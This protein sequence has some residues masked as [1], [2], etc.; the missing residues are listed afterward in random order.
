MRNLYQCSF[1]IVIIFTSSCQDNVTLEEDVL[2]SSEPDETGNLYVNNRLNES[3]LLYRASTLLREIPPNSG[4]FLVYI[5][6]TQGNTVDLKIWRKNDV[7]DLENPDENVV[8]KRWVVLLS[9]GTEEG[10]RTHWIID[11]S[12]LSF[13]GEINFSYPDIFMNGNTNLY[14]VDVYLNQMT[15]AK[16]VSLSPGV[17]INVGLG[18]NI[19]NLYYFYWFSDEINTEGITPVGWYDGSVQFLLNSGNNSVE[20]IIPTYDNSSIGRRGNII[21]TNNLSEIIRINAN[22]LPISYYMIQDVEANS[23]LDP[24]DSF[25]YSIQVGN[26]TFEARDI[27]NTILLENI[28][29]ID[30]VEE[31]GFSWEVDGV[32]DM[33]DP[34][35]ILMANQTSYRFTLHDY[36]SSSYLGYF[37]EGNTTVSIN[38]NNTQNNIKA[39]DYTNTVGALLYPVNESWEIKSINI[40]PISELVL[41]PKFSFS[42]YEISLCDNTIIDIIDTEPYYPPASV[43]FRDISLSAIGDIEYWEWNINGIESIYDPSNYSEYITQNFNETGIYDVSLTITAGGMEKSFSTILTLVDKPV[44][45]T[46]PNCNTGS[47]SVGDPVSISWDYDDQL[48]TNDHPISISI[49]DGEDH[50]ITVTNISVRE[51]VWEVDDSYVSDYNTFV[52]TVYQYGNVYRDESDEYISI[53]Y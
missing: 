11:Q 50:I 13:T 51:Y 40:Y 42:V 3:L 26:Y 31:Y 47:L 20:T 33:E 37:I 52:I 1:L 21:I 29:N 48:F 9:P 16:V 43:E 36:F 25:T 53:S 7:A 15:G 27:E 5:S 6:S 12:D 14:N 46:Y 19:Y 41:V 10:N 4:D 2:I 30:V 38:I 44:L 32:D 23:L 45:L 24:G 18:Y 8:Y 34:L 49:N 35:A 28:E 22:N 17:T 39:L